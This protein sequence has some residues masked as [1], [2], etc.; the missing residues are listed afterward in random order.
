MLSSKFSSNVNTYGLAAHST[1]TREN[2]AD[3]DNIMDGF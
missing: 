1:S 2:H 3:V